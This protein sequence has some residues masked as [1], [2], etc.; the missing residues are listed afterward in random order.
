MSLAKTEINRVMRVILAGSYNVAVDAFV[1]SDGTRRLN[2]MSCD[3]AFSK[4]DTGTLSGTDFCKD[5]LRRL[6]M[7]FAVEAQQPLAVS[8]EGSAG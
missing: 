2:S 1:P 5:M 3:H 4:Q 6:P 8:I 7:R